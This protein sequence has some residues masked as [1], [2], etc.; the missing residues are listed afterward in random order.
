MTAEFVGLRGEPEI[1]EMLSGLVPSE[2]DGLVA[3]AAELAAA[4]RVDEATERY[5]A[6][7]EQSSRHGA[8]LLGMAG[9]ALRRG[10]LKEARDT[11]LLIQPDS[12]DYEDAGRLVARV[13]FVEE[14]RRSGG[15]DAARAALGSAPDDLDAAFALAA[16]LAAAGE[17]GEALERL[18][19]I[20]ER[21]KSYRDG[22]AK[23][24]MVSIFSIVGQRSELA[25]EYRSRLAGVLY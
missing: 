6:A 5:R 20:V 4:G 3:E 10:D 11:A 9:L 12:P 19:G 16:C 24:A 1:R 2:A 17:Y 22:A 14:C 13:E 21:Q 23:D 25:D 18:V 8:A 7:L 15:M